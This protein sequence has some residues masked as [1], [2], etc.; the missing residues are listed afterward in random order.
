MIIP[1]PCVICLKSA[2]Q[3]NDARTSAVGRFL[4][5]YIS[6]HLLYVPT[7]SSIYIEDLFILSF[8]R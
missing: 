1:K 3:L 7:A 8:L 6:G 4:I 2:Q 5:L